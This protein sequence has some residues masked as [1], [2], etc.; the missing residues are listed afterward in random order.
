MYRLIGSVRN[1][2]HSLALALSDQDLNPTLTN[3]I[4]LESS[5]I[6]FQVASSDFKM[7]VAKRDDSSVWSSIR[8]VGEH[9]HDVELRLAKPALGYLIQF[10]KDALGEGAGVPHIHLDTDEGIEITISVPN[11]KP[12]MS[13]E[14]AHKILT[15]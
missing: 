1:E 4:D 9:L 5:G 7:I 10:V 14:E 6:A 12:P 3:L 13:A 2:T 15:K 11:V 8:N